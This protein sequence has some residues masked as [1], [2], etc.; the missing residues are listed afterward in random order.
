LVLPDNTENA[1]HVM[2]T[3]NLTVA[4]V[5]DGFTI[6]GKCEWIWKVLSINQ[7]IIMA[8]SGGVAANPP[9]NYEYDLLYN[10]SGG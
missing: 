5:I 1:Y 9:N 10:T 6:K 2:I 3:A 4:A 8:G 7:L